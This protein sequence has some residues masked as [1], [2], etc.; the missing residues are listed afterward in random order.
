MTFRV[1]VTGCRD[2]VDRDAIACAL[3]ALKKSKGDALVLLHGACYPKAEP[4]SWLVPL[5]SA[6]W[7]TELW[8]RENNAKTIPHPAD[9][10]RDRKAA[11]PIRNSQMVDSGADLCVA[12]WDGKSTGTLDC[13]S[14]AARAGIPVRI[15]PKARAPEATDG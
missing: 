7:L 4:P 10:P 5:R 3:G 13:F 6:D 14:K 1:I 9:W 2:W 15:V 8:A 11:G 12:F